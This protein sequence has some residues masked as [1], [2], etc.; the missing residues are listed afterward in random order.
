MMVS[1]TTKYANIKGYLV[2]QTRTS[3]GDGG[4][5]WQLLLA[6]QTENTGLNNFWA[7]KSLLQPSMRFNTSHLCTAD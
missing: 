5:A 4:R 7:T 2:S 3:K 1:F 6:Q